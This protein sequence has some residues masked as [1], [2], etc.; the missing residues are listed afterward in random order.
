[1]LSGIFCPVMGKEEEKMNPRSVRLIILVLTGL[2]TLN[3]AAVFAQQAVS[4]AITGSV[5]DP[6]GSVVPSATV[7]VTNVNTNVTSET[8]TNSEG[9][10]RIFSLVP[11]TYTVVVERTGFKRFVRENVIVGVDRIVRVDATFEVGEVTES[12]T[13]SGSTPTLKTDKSDVSQTITTHQVE[14]LPMIGRNVTRLVQLAP[15]AAL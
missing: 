7:K 14:N 9:G 13:V 5:T 2:L 10:Y 11:G 8:Q 12:V 6:T 1:M 4:G 3:V 15:G